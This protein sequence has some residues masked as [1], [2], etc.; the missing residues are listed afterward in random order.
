MNVAGFFQHW[1]IAENPFQAEEAR[2]DPVFARLGPGPTS[3]PDFEKILGDP[4]RPSSAIVFGEKGSG[5]TAIRLQLAERIDRHNAANPTSRVLLVAF[6][7]L[8]PMLDRLHERDRARSRPLRVRRGKPET[9]PRDPTLQALQRVR[10]ADHMDAILHAAVSALMDRLL[11]DAPRDAPR[12]DAAL[13]AH[14]QL[15]QTLKRLDLQSKIDLTLLQVIYDRDAGRDAKRTAA[16]RRRLRAAFNWRPLLWRTLAL[17]GWLPLAAVVGGSFFIKE[18]RIDPKWWVYATIATGAAWLLLLLKHVVIDRW[19][20]SRLAR[21]IVKQVRAVPHEQDMLSA[22]LNMVPRSIRVP[23]D[24][25]LDESEETRYAMFARLTRS[26]DKLGYAGLIVIIDRVD[27]PTTVSGD[28]DRMKA[29]VWPMMNNKF[30]QQSRVGVKM[31]LPVELKHELFRESQAF[32][33][34]ARLDKQNMVERLSWTGSTL[35]DLC[36]TRLKAC[37]AASTPPFALADMFDKP[38]TRQDVIDAL[39]QMHQPRDAF[40]FLY[41]CIA[42]HCANITQEHATANGSWKISKDVL[43]IVRKQQVERIQGVYRGVRPA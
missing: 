42:E 17:M 11:A 19:R 7:D 4:S 38:V 10:L 23:S 33:Q 27:E 29:V 3:H 9:E 18:D 1:G 30:L 36:D 28:P 14:R 8:N 16:L 35:Y 41:Q 34:E 13:E 39:D 37:L 25:P 31:L 6:D 40:K 22:A 5:K 20:M 12:D 15:R 2:H 43:D 26:L 21:R 32:F 24:L